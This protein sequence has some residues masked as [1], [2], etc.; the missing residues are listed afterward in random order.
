MDG[1][2]QIAE[3]RSKPHFIR[4]PAGYQIPTRALRI[5]QPF[6]LCP[7]SVRLLPKRWN[8]PLF[9][10]LVAYDSYHHREAL[11]E[12]KMAPAIG[13]D[14]PF[15]LLVHNRTAHTLAISPFSPSRPLLSNGSEDFE[16][17]PAYP[18]DARLHTLDIPATHIAHRRLRLV[19]HSTHGHR[20]EK[21]ESEEIL[22][23]QCALRVLSPLQNS[24]SSD[25]VR[26]RQEWKATELTGA[27]KGKVW[28]LQVRKLRRCNQPHHLLILSTYIC[29]L[30]AFAVTPAELVPGFEPFNPSRPRPQ[31]LVIC[32][33]L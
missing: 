22:L 18:T 1:A 16:A 31:Q 33:L 25:G 11:H 8:R 32:S 12:V 14:G 4:I 5:E 23:S 6:V 30:A 10:V 9:V 13:D 29:S 3:G 21:V 20:T 2:A 7:L 28:A 19:V 24:T 17:P 26:K 27:L 15:R